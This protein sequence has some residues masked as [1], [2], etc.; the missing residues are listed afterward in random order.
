MAKFYGT[1]GFAIPE[2]I[3]PGVW[4]EKIVEQSYFGDLIRETRRLQSTDQ[5][6]DNVDISNRISIVADPFANQHIHSMRYVE[7]Q[8]IR[9]KVSDVEVQYPRLILSV[10]GV[11]NG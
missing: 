7:Y 5:V 10:G 11:Y 1:I 3:S 2:E 6:N 4:E 8:G 9:W